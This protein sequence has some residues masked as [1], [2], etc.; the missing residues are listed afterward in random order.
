MKN[1]L[2][3]IVLNPC[4]VLGQILKPY[5]ITGYS[6]FYNNKDIVFA[7]AIL[8][9]K[10]YESNINI[11]TITVKNKKFELLGNIRYPTPAFFSYLIKEE[12]RGVLSDL[13]FIDQGNLNI[14][15]KD[16]TN[17]DKGFGST[18]KSKSNREYE[19][20]KAIYKHL[21]S[22]N[23]LRR[24]ELKNVE[25][26]DEI[27]AAY[28]KNN[29]NSYVAMWDLII[30]YKNFGYSK[31]IDS[32][33]KFFS[34]KIK[35]TKAYRT[36]AANLKVDRSLSLDKTFPFDKFSFGEKLSRK[37]RQQKYTLIEF[38]ASFCKPCIDTF[39][40]LVELYTAYKLKGFDIYGISIDRENEIKRMKKIIHEKEIVWTNILDDNG[41]ES[42][43]INV[44]GIPRN[45]LLDSSGKI[46][47]K[48]ISSEDLKLFLRERLSH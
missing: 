36:F 27:L 21:E 40:S 38:W 10:Y 28:I 17:K 3:F 26:K 39:P 20:L 14:E 22:E 11:R 34:A 42:K 1:I 35:Q 25:A 13:F 8:D 47:A 41:K 6:T 29:P 30:D 5:K 9:A 33:S 24:I 16:L 23:D 12:N 19:Q 2:F 15:I 7:P 45:F 37:V 31:L 18:L 44:D 48:D 46:L 43:K 4:F 32:I